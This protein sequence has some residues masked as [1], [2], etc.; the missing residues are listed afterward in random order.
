MGTKAPDVDSRGS[1]WRRWDPHVHFPGTLFNDQYGNTSIEDALNTLAERQPQ[2]EAVGVTDYFTT[3]GF[4]KA[5]RAWQEG[6]GHPIRVLFPNVELRLDIPTARGSGVNLHL[7][8]S[9]DEVDRL[10]QFLGSL[11]FT[12]NGRHYRA[13]ENGL[14]ELGR[15]FRGDRALAPN[16]ALRIGANQF[17]VNFESL[18]KQ[19]QSDRWAVENCIVAV[20]GT[21][22]DGTSGV[23]T[24][25]GSFA[26][27]RQS[28]EKF[29]N[30][31]FSSS[32]KQVEFWLGRGTDNIERL[33]QIY[34]GAK[35]CLHGSDAH[36][37][38]SLGIVNDSRFTWI[39]GDASFETL[40]MACLAPESRARIAALP[41]N[42]GHSY[43]RIANVSVAGPRFVDPSTIPINPGLVAIIGARGSGKTALADLIAVGSGSQQPFDNHSSFIS[44]AGRL[45][46][47]SVAT[48]EW[49]HNERTSNACCVNVEDS[50]R[51][52]RGVRYLSQQF[53]ERL[54][55]SDGVS[56]DL[57][58]EIERVVFNAFPAYERQGAT[59]FSELLDIRLA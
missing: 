52:E 19:F 43:G 25:D 5:S 28:I 31:I 51:E 55:A 10:D 36:N 57:L 45:L 15:D 34:G 54:C 59:N 33:E 11:E 22:G 32:P 37:V 13:D 53:V 16:A 35:L 9:P 56:D 38:R 14:I 24:D 47:S 41:P 8:C 50:G 27:R 58:E 30:I 40:R 20:A 6:A 44:R 26:A 29:A 23:R 12:W 46:K 4:R 1:I 39:K 21:Q 2:I 7:L 48:V 17:K 49:T 42:A 3:T 18:C